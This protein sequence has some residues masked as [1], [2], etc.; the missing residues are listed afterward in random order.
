MPDPLGLHAVANDPFALR[1]LVAAGA[2]VEARDDWDCTPIFY[3][4]LEGNLESLEVLIGAGA[5]V[6]VVAGEPGCTI[7]ASP[8][9]NLALQL[10]NLMDWSKYDPIVQRLELAGASHSDPAVA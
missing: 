5:D 9:L 8:P 10:R 1:G 4:I 7:L 2:D 3:V 6:N